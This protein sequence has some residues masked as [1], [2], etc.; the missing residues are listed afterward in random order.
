MGWVLGLNFYIEI[1]ANSDAGKWGVP[2]LRDLPQNGGSQY[3][4]QL[5]LLLEISVITGFYVLRVQLCVLSVDFS[6]SRNSLFCCLGEG[7][8]KN[9]TLEDGNLL[10]SC[11]YSILE[12]CVSR[13]SY[14]K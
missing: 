9:L 2:I 8:G 14:T 12:M 3:N 7:G 6:N 11:N 10:S 1:D 4:F 13:D 5:V